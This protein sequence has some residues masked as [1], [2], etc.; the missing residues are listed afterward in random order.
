MGVRILPIRILRSTAIRSATGKGT[1]LV[2]DTVGILPE[3]Y[4]AV[5]ES[6]G[7]PNNG[8]LHIIEHIH[9]ARTRHSAG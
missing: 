1:T 4:I 8:D 7:V 6:V 9:L 3:T 5:S 2:V